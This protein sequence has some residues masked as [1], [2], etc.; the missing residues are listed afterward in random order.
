MK[1]ANGLVSLRL[2]TMNHQCF[3]S[4]VPSQYREEA[5][6][7]SHYAEREQNLCVKA[8]ISPI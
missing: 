3:A 6:Q 7:Y 5:M 8:I 2:V 4:P 1:F